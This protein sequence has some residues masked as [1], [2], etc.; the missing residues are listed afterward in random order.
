[1]NTAKP[2]D[3]RDAALRALW[4]IWNKAA[5]P[6]EILEALSKGL[7]KKD[8]AFLME[9][10][11]GALRQRDLLDWVL[12]G[13]FTEKTPGPPTLDNLRLALY[14]ILFMRVP[15]HAAV[16][17]AVRL[18][19]ERTG[20]KPGLVNAVLRN[21]LRQSG[22][23]QGRLD[24]LRKKSEDPAQAVPERLRA[25]STLTSHPLWLLKRWARRFGAD[26][27]L[28]LAEANNK[29]PPLTLR[30]NLLKKTREEALDMLSGEG[31]HASPALYSPAAIKAGHA[32]FRELE[33]IQSVSQP[34]DE[35]AQLVSILLDPKPGQRVLDACAAPGGKTTHMAELMGDSGEI[36]AVDID[37]QR[38]LKLKENMAR[39]G[40]G[41]I[42]PVAADILNMDTD[43][44]LFDKILLD[45]PCS[46]LGVIRRNPDI[47]YRAREKDLPEFGKRQSAMLQKV[48]GMLKP[49]G[50]IVYS[51]CSTEPEEGE[52]V[53]NG[54]LSE[55]GCFE[56]EKQMDPALGPL[57][58]NGLFFVRTYPH[59]HD[60]DG[61]FMAKLRR[62]C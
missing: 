48:S 3:T 56:M 52:D 44:G 28:A 34:Q 36:V 1:M 6:K 40:L 45:A 33:R 58:E 51:T 17:E 41:S 35:A 26:G 25:I 60:M 15:G 47:K 19:K 39:L 22:P 32:S 9:L 20:G 8:R 14:Q 54:F 7:E 27:A 13:F 30:I 12:S 10:A 49:G 21:V 42:R 59:R 23:I 37:G 38:L 50:E 61:F 18:E 4:G 55:N 31:I 5:T 29:I 53:I 43:M 11:Y 24:V 2:K 62:I 57:Y 46:S 16:F